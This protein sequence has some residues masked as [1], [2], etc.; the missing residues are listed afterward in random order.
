MRLACPS[1]QQPVEVVEVDAGMNAQVTCAQCQSVLGVTVTATLVSQGAAPTVGSAAAGPGPKAA[2][3]MQDNEL[4]KA[5]AGALTTAGYS[6]KDASDARLA[7]E[8]LGKDVPDLVVVDGTYPPLFGMGL[9]EIIKKSNVTARAK[10]LGLRADDGTGLPV[11]GADAT[12]ALTAGTVDL[13]MEANRLVPTAGGGP[14]APAQPAPAAPEPAA[15]AADPMFSAS[16]GD[17]L[18]AVQQDAAPPELTPPPAAPEQT[19]FVSQQAAPAQ[20]AAPAAGA[21]GGGDSEDP[22]HKAAQ[23]L[24]R[25]I[26]SDIALYNQAAVAEGLANGTLREAIQPFLQE[27]LEHYQDKTPKEVQAGTDYFNEALNAWI[28]RK[29]QA[30]A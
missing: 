7:L 8:D 27:G 4:R 3:I 14:A 30:A 29:E 13:L 11:P 23:R 6:V 1:C 9:G 28:A 20:P 10:V 19:G 15:P 21:A 24:A 2:V 17:P 22:A 12:I 26:I 5:Y 16:G 25:T 18:F